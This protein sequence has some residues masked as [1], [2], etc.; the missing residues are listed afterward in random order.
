MKKTKTEKTLL[1]AALA[2]GLAASASA[3]QAQSP[4]PEALSSGGLVGT[5]YSEL[6]LGYQ[7]QDA[8]PGVLHDYGLLLNQSVVREGSF[9]FDGNFS[10]D[11]ATAGA[12]GSHDY[13]NSFMLGATGYLVE[14][15]GKPFV[16]A[17]AGLVTQQTAAATSNA[18]G[19]N[20][21]GGIEF[22][23]AGDFFLTPFATYLGDPHLQ[24]HDP[25]VATLPNNV[26]Y[27]GVKATY[28]ISR[29]WSASVTAQL[30]QHSTSDLGLRAAVSYRF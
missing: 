22:P 27:Y 15:W 6:S 5:N 29:Q 3:Q 7:K 8:T 28:R 18:L 19:Y 23:V 20:L 21:T 25:A 1:A 10:Y 24:D 16:T 2:L 17:D 26:W 30:D 13:R 9:G 14:G 4:P 11:Y 12:A